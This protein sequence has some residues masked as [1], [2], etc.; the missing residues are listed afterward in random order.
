[1]SAPKW[2]GWILARNGAFGNIAAIIY[3]FGSELRGGLFF[4]GLRGGS[5]G[6]DRV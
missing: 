2:D 6:G 3:Y 1:M 5:E 4:L